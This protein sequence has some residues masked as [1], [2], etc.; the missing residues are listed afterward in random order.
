MAVAL[1]LIGTGFCLPA[2][3]SAAPPSLFPYSTSYP[4]G[5]WP[6]AAAIGDL[7]NDGRNDVVV[8]TSGYGTA[9]YDWSIFIFYQTPSG[10]LASPVEYDA[11]GPATS[12]VIADFNGDGLNDI[13]VAN[14]TGIRVFWQDPAGGF[15]NHTDFV[16]TNSGTDGAAA[17][18][19]LCAGDFNNDGLTDL[20]GIG[21]YQNTTTMDVY[22]QTNG[23][24]SYSQSYPAAYDGY[25]DMAAG[26][27]NNDGLTDI[28]V[29]SGQG[30]GPNFDVFLQTN[31]GFAPQVNYSVGGTNLTAG[32]AIGD[33]DGDGLNEVVV[34]YGGNQ[35]FSKIA[36][37]HQTDNGLTLSAI[38]D[39]HDI[40][41]G[42]QIA[43][44]E[45]NGR[46]DVLVYHDAWAEIGVYSQNATNTLNP[47]VIYSTPFIQNFNPQCL[48]VGDIN[49]DGKPDVVIAGDLNYPYL[50]VLTNCLPRIVHGISVTPTTTFIP[51][52]P[53]G[54][55]FFPAAQ[56]FAI[57]NLFSSKVKWS[58]INTSTWL[59][60]S[61][62]SPS[63]WLGPNASTFVTVM[64]SATASTLT[65]GV[66]NAT[67]TFSASIGAPIY[68]PV[69]LSVGQPPIANG[70][71]E[72]GT[73]TNWTQSGDTNSTWVTT[74]STYIHSGNFGAALGPFSGR[75]GYLTQ[76]L[77][78]TPGQSYL[79]SFWLRNPTGLTPNQFQVQ[80]NG[81]LISSLPNFTNTVWTN[82][83]FVLTATNYVT[84]LQF[85]FED[86]LDY[87]ALDDVSVILI[88]DSFQSAARTT[89]Q[90]KLT[91]NTAAGMNYQV[92]YKTNLQQ[93][94]WINL[95]GPILATNTT[96]T[97]ADT[98]S[99]TQRYY[100]LFVSP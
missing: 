8:T 93:A 26:D 85:G 36:V 35:P 46:P 79:L 99:A 38:Y 71:F 52:G 32:V 83:H 9:Q 53:V 70:G 3:L 5:S 2:N 51:T 55:P 74:D 57:T 15:A 100:R 80:W 59:N 88:P 63:G 17:S 45:M 90:F 40:P 73:F 42:V 89:N 16:T 61:S 41:N 28:V 14:G 62:P 98:N 11:G 21:W 91:W 56:T 6:E 23:T 48:A 87:L 92:Q 31:G 68:V 1:I 86:Y 65:N 30:L 34:T 50:V 84:P 97:L 33:V 10:Q 66:Y 7:N 19:S 18:Y 82:P 39:S 94:G 95:S 47:E 29:M 20:A 13:A 49:G 96:L 22:I 37:F 67:L 25:N 78:T 81:A 27:V 54:G 72:A 60:L 58:L 76:L 44:L 12:V 69:I 64:P 4:V 77:N 24:L 43:D 75:L